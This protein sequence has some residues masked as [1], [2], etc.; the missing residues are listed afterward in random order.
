MLGTVDPEITF[1]LVKQA[2]RNC[3]CYINESVN[4]HYQAGTQPAKK[5]LNIS[6]FQKK[7]LSAV[8]YSI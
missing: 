2:I 8:N 4:N 1:S 5:P 3:N 7:T 6:P